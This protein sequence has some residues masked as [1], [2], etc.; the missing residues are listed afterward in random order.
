MSGWRIG[1]NGVLASV[2]A[3]LFWA[4]AEVLASLIIMK[5]LNRPQRLSIDTSCKSQYLLSRKKRDPLLYRSFPF[6]GCPSPARAWMRSGFI[7]SRR[8]KR[9]PLLIDG[10]HHRDFSARQEHRLS[11]CLSIRDALVRKRALVS[12]PFFSPLRAVVRFSVSLPPECHDG[13]RR[14]S[15]ADR[16]M[17]R[18]A[19]K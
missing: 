2:W 15:S 19:A 12:S 1:V 8:E 16:G 14:N 4:G 5:I 17:L 10:P 6:C 18:L 13:E 3:C 11:S 7:A 9:A